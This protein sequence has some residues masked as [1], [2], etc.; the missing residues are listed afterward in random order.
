MDKADLIQA[1]VTTVD[2]KE[3]SRGENSGAIG[4]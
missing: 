4:I 1:K 2:R 3:W